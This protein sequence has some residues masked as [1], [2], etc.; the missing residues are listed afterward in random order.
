M[1]LPPWKYKTNIIVRKLKVTGKYLFIVLVLLLNIILK[2]ICQSINYHL[3][4]PSKVIA[5]LFYYSVK[6]N[7]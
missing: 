2:D 6:I 4:L 3:A 1:K 7:N 5:L